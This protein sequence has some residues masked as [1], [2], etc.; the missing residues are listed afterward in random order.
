M[1]SA[2]SATD[3]L[4]AV[5]AILVVI[6]GVISLAWAWGI[7]MVVPIA[8]GLGALVV[9]F[10]DRVAPAVTLPMARGLLLLVLG[11]AA[12]LVWILVAIQWIGYILEPPIFT[13]DTIQFF[14]GL[15]GA[16]LLAFAGWRAYA[17]D[18]GSSTAST[19]PPAPPAPPAV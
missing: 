8:A 6:F 1:F 15:I 17:A 5:G 16:I 2:L 9:V 11:A 12:L 4:G 10:K 14:I 19:P 18:Q 13:A 3:R 7:L